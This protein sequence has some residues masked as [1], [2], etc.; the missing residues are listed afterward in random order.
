MKKHN[1]KNL[2]SCPFIKR[3]QTTEKSPNLLEILLYT[4]ASLSQNFIVVAS[5]VLELLSFV[6][7]IYTTFLSSFSEN[8][9]NGTHIWKITKLLGNTFEHSDK[10][11]SKFQCRSLIRS[12]V[13]RLCFLYI[14]ILYFHALFQKLI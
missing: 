10:P 6:F 5:F 13:I 3:E 11:Q 8:N 2:W 7:Y 1:P 9:K 14:Y 12:W 4:S